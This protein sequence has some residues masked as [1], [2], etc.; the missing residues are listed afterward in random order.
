LVNGDH[1]VDFGVDQG[2]GEADEDGYDDAG[3][4]ERPEGQHLGHWRA[5]GRN[6]VAPSGCSGGEV[7]RGEVV[8][9]PNSVCLTMRRISLWSLCSMTGEVRWVR[10][11]SA[12]QGGRRAGGQWP[13]L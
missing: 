10:S 9:R 5:V 12:A 8:V 4:D 3:L 1:S 13:G 2:N 7:V 11:R 6:V